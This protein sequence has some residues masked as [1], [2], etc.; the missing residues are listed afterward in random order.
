MGKAVVA[1]TTHNDFLFED[2]NP[3]VHVRKRFGEEDAI[4]YYEN[5][6][7]DKRSLTEEM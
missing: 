5:K 7:A 1:E 6:P 3:S 2:L 4:N